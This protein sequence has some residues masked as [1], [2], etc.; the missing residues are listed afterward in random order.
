M[1]ILS[2]RQRSLSFYQSLPSFTKEWDMIASILEA[3]P[4]IEQRVWEDLT[5][6]GNG[7]RKKPTGAQGMPAEQVVRFA[8]VKMK[9]RLSYRGLQ[10]WVA[11]SICLRGFCLVGSEEVSVFIRCRKT[12]N[13]SGRKHGRPSTTLS[14]G[15]HATKA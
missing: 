2:Q 7:G 15:M 12:S 9:E 1:R 8:V 13:A 4:E 10:A 6:N 14:P 11:D 5:A 3:N